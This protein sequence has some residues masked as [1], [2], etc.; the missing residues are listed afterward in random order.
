MVTT[1][2]VCSGSGTLLT[3]NLEFVSSAEQQFVKAAFDSQYCNSCAGR[4]VSTR[5]ALKLSF[6]KLELLPASTRVD[7]LA[8]VAVTIVKGDMAGA[9]T[10]VVLISS[11]SSPTPT[12]T[13]TSCM[14]AGLDAVAAQLFH[15]TGASGAHG[16]KC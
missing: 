3:V 5:R 10:V 11:A 15:V 9:S 4:R 6:E 13:A 8:S 16:D 1:T 12:K 2:G 7:P 14:N